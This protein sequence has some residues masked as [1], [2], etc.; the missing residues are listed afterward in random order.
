MSCKLSICI[1]TIHAFACFSFI[2]ISSLLKVYHQSLW[3]IRFTAP[4]IHSLLLVFC[5][6]FTAF[7]IFLSTNEYQGPTVEQLDVFLIALAGIF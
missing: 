3:R 2:F 5:Q 6:A 7:N 1:F 4:K